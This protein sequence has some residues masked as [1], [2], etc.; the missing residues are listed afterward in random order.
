M[1]LKDFQTKEG[2][3][4][5]APFDHR[6]SLVESLHMDLKNPS[7]LEKF[8]TLKRMFMEVLSPHVS[9]VLTDP[10]YG[11]KTLDAKAATCALFLSLEAS[12]YGG[13]QEAP[14]EFLPNWGVDQIK[15]KGAG[16][17]L[18]VYFNPDSPLSAA[19]IEAVQAIYEECKQK[20]V[21][22]LVEPVM[23][24]VPEDEYWSTTY[25]SVCRRFAPLCDILKIQYPGS[26][27]ACKEVSTFHQ[28]WI[29][30]SRGVGYFKFAEVLKVA[31]SA[32][33]KGY[34]AG[35]AVW[36][37][38]TNYSDPAQWKNFLETTSVE[39]LKSLN[40]LLHA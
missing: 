14:I 9:A 1:I 7:D 35:R 5:I 13:V 4:A 10:E 31:M 24:K 37:E 25:L 3:Y 2:F 20:E 38:L 16:A 28:N 21:V 27:D 6:G 36:Q 22:F 26:L 19:K 32:G 18:L 12:S 23:Y 17:K 34:A 11:I 33:C 30:L 39:R 29:L 8:I 15:E 40:T